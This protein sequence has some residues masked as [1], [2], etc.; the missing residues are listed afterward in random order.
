MEQWSSGAVEQW[1]SGADLSIL[2]T[3]QYFQGARAGAYF[4]C[5]PPSKPTPS[6]TPSFLHCTQYSVTASVQN[7]PAAFRIIVPHLYIVLRTT[8]QYHR[9][10]VRRLLQVPL[11]L[12]INTTEYR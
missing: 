8:L 9:K 3:V 11:L 12:T 7:I 2:H 10:D 4:I 1:S 6:L 5:H